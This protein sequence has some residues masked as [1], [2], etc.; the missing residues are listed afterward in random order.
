MQKRKIDTN[1]EDKAVI[2]E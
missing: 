2:L 1:I